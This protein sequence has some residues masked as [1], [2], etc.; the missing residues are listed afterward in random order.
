MA[1]TINISEIAAKLSHDIFRHFHW[2]KNHKHDDNFPCC[3][4]AHLKGGKSKKKKDTHPGDVVFHYIDPYLGKRIYLHTDLKSYK[5]ESISATA[6]RGALKSLALTTECARES[7]DWRAKY[8]MDDTESYEVR[9]MLFVHNHDYQY[10]KSFYEEIKKV[11]LGTLPLAANLVLHFLGPLDIQRLYNVAND[12][13]RLK[14]E[15]ELPKDYSFYYPDLKML[16]RQGDVWGQPATIE[17]MSGPFIVIKHKKADKCGQGY[18]IYYNRKGDSVEEFEYLLD[19]LSHYQMLDSGET[20]R[21]RVTSADAHSDLK[22]IFEKAKTRYAKAW[23][24]AP[25]R[26]EILDQIQID[27]IASVATTYNP[28]DIGWRK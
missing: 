1:E 3:N 16:R 18:L 19:C 13:I 8:V 15:D 26:S 21:I 20:L 10:G 4:D 7:A 6:L 2:E 17:T 28:G 27:R 12:L 9:G 14:G 24:F 22:S 23:G 25:E 5:A 11:D